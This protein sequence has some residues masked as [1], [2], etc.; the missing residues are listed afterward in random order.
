MDRSS[1]TTSVP[2]MSAGIRSGVNW[3]R[4]KEREKVSATDLTRS[5][6]PSPGT[7]PPPPPVSRQ[8]PR[9]NRPVINSS[10]IS[11]CPIT[12]FRNSR[13]IRSRAEAIFF[14]DFGFGGFCHGKG[15]NRVITRKTAF[16]PKFRHDR[17]IR[18]RHSLRPWTD[19]SHRTRLFHKGD[20]P[21]FPCNAIRLRRSRIQGAI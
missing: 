1:S 14:E 7:P 11:S 6:F 17:A 12:T 18:S 15:R 5:V 3:M 10:M 19:A 21:R 2:N 13:K 4:L 20:S 8:W 16:A 9:A